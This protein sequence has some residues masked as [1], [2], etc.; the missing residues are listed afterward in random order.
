MSIT[1]LPP[2][3]A[4]RAFEAAARH[5]SFTRAAEELGMTQAAV[6]YQIRLL[7]ERLGAR[8]FLREARR[9]VLTDV[10][11]RLA[12]AV[13]GAFETL[14]AA[15]AHA[16]EDL[17]GVLRI[18]AVNSFAAL[19]LAP[20]LGTFQMSQRDLAVS[21]D[22]SNHIVDF[23]RE[24][25]DCAIRSGHGDWPGLARHFLFRIHFAPLCSPA[26][27]PAAGDAL[28]PADLLRLPRL[29]PDDIWWTEWFASLGIDMAG[30]PARG[31]VRLD[32][33]AI[34]GAAAIAG[35]GFA[36]LA[37]ALWRN[38]L[39]SGRLVQPLPHIAFGTGNFWLV[40]PE[41]KRNTPKIRAF[42]DWLLGEIAD[43]AATDTT[44][45]FVPPDGF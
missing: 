25:V 37:P 32:S 39:L 28:A 2:L 15:F 20:R 30:A 31:S 1:T 8:L 14:I 19:W 33:Q 5:E 42:R 40:Y 6:S 43:H 38:D 7:E 34:E 45:A 16:R 9:V 29:S 18:S 27:L 3:T 44:G 17:G 41:Y 12:P 22:A 35:Q 36:V 23:A 13:T 21:L 26:L 10:G 24:E 4:I 11:R